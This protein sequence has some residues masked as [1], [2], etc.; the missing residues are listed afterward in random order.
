[1]QVLF[2]ICLQRQGKQ[3]KEKKELT[4]YGVP[5]EVRT[6]TSLMKSKGN[7]RKQLRKRPIRITKLIVLR[8]DC[9]EEHKSYEDI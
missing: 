7:Q 4:I 3:Q 1:M 8:N 2:Y 6:S 9:S 5:T